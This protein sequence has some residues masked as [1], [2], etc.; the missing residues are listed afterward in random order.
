MKVNLARA[1]DLFFSNSS[2][3]MVYFEAIV[4]AIDAG[5]SEIS[6]IIDITSPSEPK[7]LSITITDNG[8]GF[9]DKNFTKFSSLLETEGTNH[10]GLGRLVY[11]KY[12]N[13]IS[14]QSVYD[15]DKQRS[16]MLTYDFQG[17]SKNII[18]D[19]GI[20]VGTK[21]SF[22]DYIKDKIAKYDYITPTYLV[23][24][25]RL[26][27]FP[28]LHR[29]KI[30]N[31]KLEIEIQLNINDT[32]AIGELI[33]E[34]RIL[35]ASD[36]PALEMK[37]FKI[38][39]ID[40]WE[41]F[42]LYYSVIEK[43]IP[44]KPITALSIDERTMDL[45]LLVKGAIP[46]THEAIFI[47]YSTLFSGKVT[48][49]RLEL[50]MSEQ[51]I[52]T[53][54]A[55]FRNKINEII[56]E[57]IPQIKTENAVI[58]SKLERKYPHLIGL[59]Q[60]TYTGLINENDAIE[61]AQRNFFLQQKEILNADSLTE[62]QFE[63]SLEISSRILTEYILYRQFTIKRLQQINS[64]NLEDD[65][66]NIIVPMRQ[67]FQKSDLIDDVFNNN[68]WL[69]DDK[70]MTYNTV[71]SDKVMSK[72]IREIT[73]DE[74]VEPNNT[75][76]DIAIIFSN[77]PDKSPKVDVVIVELK[78]KGASLDEN[79]IVVNQLQTRARHLMNFFESK[80]QRIW[81]YAIVDIDIEF[82]LWLENNR[83]LKVY[84]TGSYYYREDMLRADYDSSESHPVGINILSFDAFVKD[85]D[86]RNSTFLEILKANI[87]KHSSS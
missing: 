69:L 81:F 16:F 74:K 56:D 83:F 20:L 73:K 63:K 67:M 76:P 68:I 38:D 5:A 11:L 41:D 53:I 39:P 33:P 62:E 42:E 18:D 9:T 13:E 79:T 84:S 12:F 45:N 72:V 50:E 22:R 37:S 24:V 44:S 58:K 1:A 25:I 10:K 6:I 57:K 46:K 71:L 28:L 36:I 8:Q 15:G 2:L 87:R 35:R 4:N 49:S 7:S 3:E 55:V 70:Y 31:K 34:K 27:F 14:F 75:E 51:D 48:P 78:K 40:M 30:A 65:I 19:T 17:E 23:D 64:D 21:L 86:S 82:Q 29:Y 66:H 54:K 77:D 43:T 32:T 52:K 60:E 85:A 47:L 61:N 59:F 26:H 80:I